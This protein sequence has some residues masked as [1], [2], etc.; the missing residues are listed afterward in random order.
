MKICPA[1]ET[2]NNNTR[3]FCLNC[4]ERLPDPV[5]GSDPGFTPPESP[6]SLPR[7][8]TRVVG[9]KPIPRRT[10]NAGRN[11][12]SLVL[13]LFFWAVLAGLAFGIYLFAQP[14]TKIQSPVE[15]DS[16]ASEALGAF[17]KK[18]STTPGGAWMGSADSINRFLL[19]NVR[20]VPV[21]TSMGLHTEFQRCFVELRE[22]RLDFVMQQSLQGYPL[23]FTLVLEPYSQDGDWKVRFAGASLGRL[24]VPAALAP[25][26]VGLWQPCFDSL[27]TVVDKLESAVS[28]S[29]T[30]TSLVI[31]WPGKSES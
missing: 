22:G 8:A 2:E 9:K 25:F 6:L 31:R 5:P 1:C 21:S 29:V 19:E 30:P 15:S 10:P 28:A 11:F 13:N 16:A 20:L 14:P 4:R 18:A 26:L 7:V 24:P 3:V 12:F 23:Y 27:A 17:F